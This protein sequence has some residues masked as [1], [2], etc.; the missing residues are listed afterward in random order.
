MSSLTF[1]VL[2]PVRAWH[3]ETEIDLGTPKQRALLALLLLQPGHPLSPDEIV[4]V[5]WGDDPPDSAQNQVQ[6]H[7][8]ALRRL[9]ESD[10]KARGASR[11]LVR[12]S[13]GYRLDVDPE[14][15]DLG[16]FRALRQRATAESLLE[17]L[18]LWR[19]PVAAGIPDEIRAH[20][21]FVAVDG[22]YL[23]AVK[24]AADL[25]LESDPEAADRVLGLVR[26]SAARHPL[27]EALQA[28]LMMLLAATG[29]QAEALEV[30]Q[31][32]RQVL[33][34]DLGLDPG[35]ELQAAH[36]RVLKTGGDKPPVALQT[37]A[38]LPADLA[39]FAGR[40]QELDQFPRISGR[41]RAATVVTISGMAGVGKTTLAVHW[42]HR[43][44]DHFPD[45]QIYLDLHGFHPGRAITSPADALHS[46]LESLGVPAAAVP[47]SL[48]AQA[49]LFRSLVARRRMLVVLDNARDT[50]QVRPLLPGA[51][52]CL[53]VVTSRNQLYD[54]VAEHGATPITL[55]RLPYADATELLSRRL[56]ADRVALE[57]TA[58][59]EIVELAGRLPLTL[60]MVSARAAMNPRFSLAAIAGELERSHGSLDA[61]VGESADSD[62]RSIFDWSYQIL[63][64]VAARLFRLLALHPG[65]DCS[66]E[67][68]AGLA[69]EAA[70]GVRQ[71]FGELQRAN[72]VAET[73]P[74]RFALHDLLRAYA[75][76]LVRDDD[77]EPAR[78]RLRDYYLHSAAAANRLLFPGRE[79]TPLRPPAAG[80]VTA[81]F[82]YAADAATWFDAERPALV[83]AIKLRKPCTWQLSTLVELYLDRIGAWLIQ[84]EVQT[85]ALE[86]ADSPA[87]VAASERALGFA[88]GRLGHWAASDGHLDRALKIF[89]EIGDGNGLARTHRLTAFL[90][91]RR[92]RHDEALTHY[93]DASKLYEQTGYANGL[94]YVHNEIGWTYILIGDHAKALEECR[95]AIEG[96]RALGD[97]NG[98][99]AAWDSMGYAQHHL[100]A[101][102][103]AL[104]SFAQSMRLYRSVYDR[105]LEAET[106]VHIGDT[107]QA[108][109]RPADAALA[110]QQALEIFEDLG[111]P[112]AG[113]VH[114]RMRLV[115]AR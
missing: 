2:G 72:L 110:W 25:V 39:A 107:H 113:Q 51:P 61:F 62:I 114:D 35:A 14:S 84:V 37:P 1:T 6:R 101:Y 87:G 34:D 8:G 88:E 91:N 93:A 52:G 7:V 70:G 100:G 56:G 65:P 13:G 74:G 76:E 109:G 92:L 106:L 75:R 60:A 105:P 20:P 43:I 111:H 83:A 86:A 73:E 67:A 38:Q 82:R 81:S 78:E 54:L 12:G 55:E 50:A 85:A 115:E 24:S 26:E 89:T 68:A 17:A 16:R 42:A 104:E 64:P 71:S 53:T 98:E 5:L 15:V 21:A 36:Q 40:R 66:V 19:G 11:F 97:R 30:F 90:L 23:S 112:D 102:D 99:A 96:H 9:F 32:T 27:D 95:L 44:A 58:S 41:P 77:V 80:V 47:A 59:A 57:Q 45:G 48:E 69:G 49:A 103:D 108:A 46:V 29:K 63:T 94:A 31:A 28:R 10:L 3:G 22:E 18:A 33:A 79:E 4:A